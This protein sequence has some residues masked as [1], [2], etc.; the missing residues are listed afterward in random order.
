MANQ[1]D[2]EFL[3]KIIEQLLPRHFETLADIC[4]NLNQAR[5]H[6]YSKLPEM[7]AW[8]E[9]FVRAEPR[10]SLSWLFLTVPG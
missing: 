6:L 4:L 7:Q 9:V 8:A 1:W 2:I 10:V 3:R 5:E